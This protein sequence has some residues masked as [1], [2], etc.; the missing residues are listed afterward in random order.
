M[1]MERNLISEFK[2]LRNDITPRPEWI[3]SSRDILL[4]TISAQ[5]SPK[6]VSVGLRGYFGLAFQLF[7][8]RA[9]EPAIVMG[10]VLLTFLISSFTVNAAFYSLPGGSLYPLKLTLE[11][12]HV[13]L[14]TNEQK[15]V[16][17]RIEFAEKRV[18]ELDRVVSQMN[19]APEEK[20]KQIEAI[21][22][23]FRNNVS[24]VGEHV[25]KLKHAAKQSSGVNIDR[26]NTVMMALTAGNKAE[27]LAKTFDQKVDVLSDMEKVGVK[28]IVAEAIESAQQTTHS[29]QQ[30]LRQSGEQEGT[31]QGA[32]TDE[33]ATTTNE[34][35]NVNV[36]IQTGGTS[37]F[38]ATEAGASAGT[39]TTV[40]VA[41]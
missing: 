25:V 41:N 14:I 20:Q 24:S 12:T 10:A 28:Q 33:T 6:L 15:K 8:Q 11:R 19:V 31:V 9:F 29:A 3:T 2:K 34:K 26:D 23:E 18:A 4:Q 22:K 7:R 37:G 27:E 5:S 16:E 21:A 17:L 13:A 30:L 35:V 39:E 1:N 32:A 36:K 38:G 40:E